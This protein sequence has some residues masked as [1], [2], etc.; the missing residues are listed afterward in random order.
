MRKRWFRFTRGDIVKL[1]PVFTFA[2]PL[3]KKEEQLEEVRIL[4]G[5]VQL[6]QNRA[7]KSYLVQSVSCPQRTYYLDERFLKLVEGVK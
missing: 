6:F 7:C 1:S 3:T 4:E 2:S 5:R